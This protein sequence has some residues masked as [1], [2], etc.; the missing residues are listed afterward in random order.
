MFSETGNVDRALVEQ[1]VPPERPLPLTFTYEVP[2][3]SQ[4]TVQLIN[5]R[6]EVV[7]IIR[8]QQQPGLHDTGRLC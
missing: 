5:D 3:D 4:V 8:P 2:Q 6:N 7:R 1:G